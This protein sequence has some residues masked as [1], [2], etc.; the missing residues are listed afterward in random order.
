MQT[1]IDYWTTKCGTDEK[2]RRNAFVCTA[3]YEPIEFQTI[4]PEWI[5]HE[6]VVEMN[7]EVRSL[8]LYVVL[9]Q[10]LNL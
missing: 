3:G 10:I 4:F 7:C 2:Y 8:T 9:Y 6:N 5:V 1:V